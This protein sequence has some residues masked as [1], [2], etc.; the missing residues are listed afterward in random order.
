LWVQGVSGVE[1]L[2]QS[3]IQVAIR[4]GLDRD[5]AVRRQLAEAYVHVRSLR[6]L[7]YKGF[8]TFAQTSSAPEHS[9]L[10]LATAELG[11][12]LFELGMQLLGPYGAVMDPE[13]GEQ[14]GRFAFGLFMSFAN[15][16]AGGSSEIQR[17]I[18]AE[19]ILG[20]PRK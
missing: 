12:S 16:L 20:L 13:R 10:K 5:P 18:I 9:F 6:T 2:L 14:R 8:T 19:R 17:N 7:G 11:K 1:Y 4:R 3:L 15:T